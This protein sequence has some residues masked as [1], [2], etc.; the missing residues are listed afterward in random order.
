MHFV[1]TVSRN[2]LEKKPLSM[3]LL[4]F[5]L[6]GTTGEKLFR[7][8]LL[9]VAWPRL[10]MGLASL[11]SCLLTRIQPQGKRRVELDSICSQNFFARLPARGLSARRWTHAMLNPHG[12]PCVVGH[13]HNLSL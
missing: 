8:L 12:F 13:S 5:F 6:P 2:T 9:L 10:K 3:L 7:Q 1:A 11:H 4:F